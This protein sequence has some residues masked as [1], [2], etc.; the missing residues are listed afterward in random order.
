MTQPDDGNTR[1][2]PTT[3]AGIPVASQEHSPTVGPD[4]PILLQADGEMVRAAYTL[5]PDDDDISQ[6][7]VLINEVMDD[8]AR[9]R[10]VANVAGHVARCKRPEVIQRVF[11]YWRNIDQA[12]GDRIEAAVKPRSA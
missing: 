12:I 11:D 6:P 3:D 7:R 5:R 10:L 4:G 1:P 2:A 8:A 9:D